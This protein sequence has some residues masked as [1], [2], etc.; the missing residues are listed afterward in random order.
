MSNIQMGP[1]ASFNIY[2]L[3]VLQLDS[4]RLSNPVLSATLSNNLLLLAFNKAWMSKM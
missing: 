3:G 4:L 1:L 2:F